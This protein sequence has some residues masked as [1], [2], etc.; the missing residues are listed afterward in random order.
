MSAETAG[1]TGEISS[2]VEIA[3]KLAGAAMSSSCIW[4]SGKFRG[5]GTS[6]SPENR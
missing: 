3:G 4:D 1:S 2:P 5:E 6:D